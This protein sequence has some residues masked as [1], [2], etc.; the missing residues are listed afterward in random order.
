MAMEENAK[1]KQREKKVFSALLLSTSPHFFP[2]S[3]NAYGK[4]DE[5][6]FYVHSIVVRVKIAHNHVSMNG[7]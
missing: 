7:M 2:S 4:Q 1:V 6:L 3:L 5:A